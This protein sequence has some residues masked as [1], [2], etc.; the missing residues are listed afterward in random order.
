MTVSRVIGLVLLT[1]GMALTGARPSLAAGGAALVPTPS[2]DKPIRLP[3]VRDYQSVKALRD[4]HFDFGKA[5][6][7]PDDEE[8]LD[9]NAAW[10]RANPAYLL[11]IEG[12]AD[13]RGTSEY[14]LALG[15]RRARAAR[16]YLIAQGVRA[17]RISV[18]SYGED[19]PVCR[20][21]SEDC[22]SRNRRAHFSV[23]QR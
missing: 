18:I 3:P 20:E 2:A 15:D 12:H 8:I 5:T 23:K 13:E 7:R 14:N 9:A 19:R 1:A 6:I 21:S 11:L 4:I 10:L 16:S 22:W 17:N